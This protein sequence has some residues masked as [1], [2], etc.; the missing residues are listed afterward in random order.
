MKK[1]HL[2]V[3]KPTGVLST[4]IEGE[5]LQYNDELISDL[6]TYNNMDEKRNRILVSKYSNG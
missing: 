3:L 2:K 4:P 5:I 6:D 1:L